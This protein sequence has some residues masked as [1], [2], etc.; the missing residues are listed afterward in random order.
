MQ[1]RV[2]C[3][4]VYK[5]LSRECKGRISWAIIHTH[6]HSTHIHIND[7]DLCWIDTHTENM[8]LPY[9]FF[10]FPSLHWKGEGGGFSVSLFATIERYT[11]TNIYVFYALKTDLF[12]RLLFGPNGLNLDNIDQRMALLWENIYIYIYI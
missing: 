8:I 4:C 3:F 7:K 12:E 9:L 1:F 2:L 11:I 5:F 10:S 6:T